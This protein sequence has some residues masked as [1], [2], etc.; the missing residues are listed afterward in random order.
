MGH[1]AEAP[2]VDRKNAERFLLF[3]LGTHS[4]A[5]PV[6]EVAGLVEYRGVT[7]VPGAVEPVLGLAEWRGNLLSVIDLEGLLSQPPGQ[8]PPCLVRLM[9]PLEHTAFRLCGSLQVADAPSPAAGQPVEHAGGSFEL[10]DSVALV[11]R[12]ETR[13]R[14]R[15]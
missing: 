5:L 15:R 9:P 7:P 6:A 10:L 3:R 4:Y 1:P 2:P 14:D 11:R 8:A 12:L 13:L